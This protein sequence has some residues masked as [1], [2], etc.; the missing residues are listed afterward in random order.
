MWFHED[1]KTVFTEFLPSDRMDG[2]EMVIRFV[3]LRGM[4]YGDQTF[5]GRQGWFCAYLVI[6]DRDY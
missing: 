1:D 4:P 6:T 3:R 2:I 5:C